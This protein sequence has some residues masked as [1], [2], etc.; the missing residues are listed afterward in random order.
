MMIGE[1]GGLNGILSFALATFLGFFSERLFK[2]T[3][4]QE[5]FR[6]VKSTRTSELK[7][8]NEAI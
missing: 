7:S 1:V 3:L 4:V 5:L 2:A 8:T 6:R